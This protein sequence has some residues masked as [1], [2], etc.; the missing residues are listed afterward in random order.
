[1]THSNIDIPNLNTPNANSKIPRKQLVRYWLLAIIPL[2]L[3]GFLTYR[4]NKNQSKDAPTASSENRPT[5]VLTT[6]ASLVDI[7]IVLEGLGNVVPLAMVTVRSQIDGRLQTV[8]FKEGQPVKQG[9]LIAQ[10]DARPYQI[11]LLNAQA[12]LARDSATMQ[13]AKLNF[14]R[15]RALRG[16]NLVSQQQVDDLQT[17]VAQSEAAINADNSLIQAAKLQIEFARIVSPING[18]TG[19]RLVD[20]GNLVR[21]SDPQGIVV[22]TQLDPIG[23]M[24]SLPEEN[25]FRI[26]QAL[27]EG[28][29]FVEAYSRDGITLL[30]QG[31]LLVIDN[32]INTATST[33]RLKATFPNAEKRLWP[34]AF[35]KAR[36][37]LSTRKGVTAV[38]SAAI[39]RGPQ[40]TFV[41]TVTSDQT[42]TIRQ[43]TIDFTQGDL[44][45]IASGIAPGENVVTEG[46]NLLRPGGKVVRRSVRPSDDAR[47]PRKG[48]SNTFA[49]PSLSAET[50]GQR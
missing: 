32:Q 18:V 19:V 37:K 40:G 28:A 34:N 10:V 22:I 44:T 17:S 25:Q 47:A 49:A 15:L 23:V 48:Q 8:A 26:S 29:V 3:V 14:E 16:E 2:L 43:V 35:V 7:P 50:R 13:N 12:A 1:M 27:S 45:V 36:L 46:Q 9:Q 38:P 39:Q 31:Q 5:P 20:Q 41:Y 42:A 11:Q 30:A 24:F 4:F 21:A 33:I 6:E